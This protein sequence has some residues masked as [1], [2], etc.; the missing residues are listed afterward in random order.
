MEKSPSKSTGKKVGRPLRFPHSSEV[1]FCMGKH[2]GKSGQ[3]LSNNGVDMAIT[4]YEGDAKT[5]IQMATAYANRIL[6]LKRHDEMLDAAIAVD[7]T[8]IATETKDT[9]ISIGGECKACV[10]L[11]SKL[12][13]FAFASA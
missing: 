8:I 9:E 10:D 4:I 12:M 6:R 5:E 11:Q 1:E 2:R 13:I 3:V 7:P